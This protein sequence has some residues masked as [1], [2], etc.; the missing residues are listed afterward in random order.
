MLYL[1]PHLADWPTGGVGATLPPLGP[2][3]EDRLDVLLTE[4]RG[5]WLAG[6]R[7]PAEVY[8]TAEPSLGADP[9][10]ALELIYHE[11]LV[12]E[13][14]GERPSLADYARRFPGQAGRLALQVE[15]HRAFEDTLPA[16]GPGG[17]APP[18]PPGYRVL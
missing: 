12:R 16:R 1:P 18:A 13:E 7:V 14:L 11:F 17:E 5:R 9:E 2:R 3:A 10:R 15:L 6:D 8:L 4:L